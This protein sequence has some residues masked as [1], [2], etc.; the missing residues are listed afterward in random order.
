M[1]V[2][3]IGTGNVATVLSKLIIKKGYIITEIVGREYDNALLIA[4]AIGAKANDTIALINRT[5]D[6]YIIAV[7]DDA[8]AD[9]ARQLQLG[10]KLV[11][12]TA[13]SINKN[14]LAN[15]SS[16]YGVLWPLQTLRKEMAEIPAVPFVIDANNEAALNTLE[17]FGKSISP[18]C[19]RANENERMKL[20]L[21]AVTVSN[22]TNHLYVLAE[23]YC[24]NEGL[25]FGLLLPLIN[26]T[27]QRIQHHLPK[28]VQT[29]PAIRGDTK[30]IETHLQLL[31]KYPF[32]QQVYQLLSNSIRDK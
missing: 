26:E 16:N 31:R 11:V 23:N 27:V 13:G 4:E 6:I 30:T 18:H 12:H 2:V 1:Q 3:I 25:D 21:A 10:D 32:F 28:N 9:V 20:H 19:L 7:S 5:A 17:I 22:F 8:I 24:I 14:V 15:S 29:G